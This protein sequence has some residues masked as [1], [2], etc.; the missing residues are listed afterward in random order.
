[1]RNKELDLLPFMRRWDM[2]PQPG[3]RI[4]CAVSGGRD[5][6][7]LLHYLWRLGQRED[8]TVAAVHMNHGQRDTA[9]RDELFVQNFCRE[10]RIPCVTER[11]SVP[12]KAKEWGVGIEEAGRRLRYETFRRAAELT[13]SDRIATA[14]HAADQAETVLLNLLRGTGPQGLAGIPPVRGNI[15]RPLLETSRQEIEEYLKQNGI[16]HIEDETNGDTSM[17]RNRLRLDIMPL[18]KEL[19]PGAEGSIC[20]TAE[21]LRREEE[22]WQ[23]QVDAVLPPKGTEMDRADLL[24]LP[25]ALRLR[26]LRALTERTRA[27]RKDFGA[28]HYEAMEELLCSCGGSISLPGGLV[29][30]CRGGKFALETVKKAPAG[31]VL[32]LGANRWGEFIIT[33][34][35][36]N[37][38]YLPGANEMALGRDIMECPLSVRACRAGD[39]LRLPG[40]RGRR[41]VKRLCADRGMDPGQRDALP[42]FYAGESLA[43]VWPLGVDMEFRPRET[44]G[45]MIIIQIN[46]E[47]AGGYSNG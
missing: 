46:R 32:A 13:Q 10:R 23:A 2:L 37:R 45:E 4:L 33:C 6:M 7:C 35:L 18:L 29:A 40:G 19:Y 41:S 17:T 3:G 38:D 21:I 43:A 31:A 25:Y 15:I 30:V 14:H 26:L 12:E 39:G 5:S 11:V 8:F 27:G 9:R 16:G 22:Y 20:R 42:A 1:M 28:A 24:R 36:E 34:R 47:I 44:D